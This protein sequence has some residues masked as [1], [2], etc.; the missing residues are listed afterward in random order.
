M[1]KTRTKQVFDATNKEII[2]LATKLTR[3]TLILISNLIELFSITLVNFDN[4][5][6]HDRFACIDVL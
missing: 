6:D 1:Q 4:M 3:E 2:T 5:Y